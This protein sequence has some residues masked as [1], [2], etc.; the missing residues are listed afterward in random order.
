MTHALRPLALFGLLA[1]VLAAGS[2]SAQSHEPFTQARFDA[3]QAQGALVLVDVYAEWCPT[4]A[5]QQRVLEAYREAHPDVPLHVLT[6]DFDDQKPVVRQLRAPRQSTL[7]LFRGG[8][9]VWFSVA[10]TRRDA[11]SQ[12]L[13]E[14]AAGRTPGR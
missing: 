12:A 1:F 3:L 6:V 9:R 2:A 8:E 14:A 11:I 7:I 4:C 10:E 13:N 5:Q